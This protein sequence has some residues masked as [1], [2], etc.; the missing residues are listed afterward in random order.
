LEFRSDIEETNAR[1]SQGMEAESHLLQE[2]W[3]KKQVSGMRLE[4]EAC[5]ETV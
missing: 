2:A 1:G 4:A 5:R 3:L